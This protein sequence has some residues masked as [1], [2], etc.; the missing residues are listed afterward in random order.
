[1]I[2]AKLK[3]LL[4]REKQ[5]F[6]SSFN[7]GEPSSKHLDSYQELQRSFGIPADGALIEQT[8]DGRRFRIRREGAKFVRDGEII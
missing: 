2:R 6:Y 4:T 8:P 3:A 1:M 5:D 7:M